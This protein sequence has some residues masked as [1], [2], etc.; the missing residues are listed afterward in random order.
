VLLKSH[1][2]VLPECQDRLFTHLKNNLS[3][4]V[5]M[6]RMSYML[7]RHPFAADIGTLICAVREIDRCQW[8]YVMV[9]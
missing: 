2:K 3:D 1:E 4:N 9:S 6:L 8:S 7:H 5:G